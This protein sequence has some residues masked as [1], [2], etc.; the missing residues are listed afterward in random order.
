MNANSFSRQGLVSWRKMFFR[1]GL[2]LEITHQEE[3]HVRSQGA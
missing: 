3:L 1:Q 2:D